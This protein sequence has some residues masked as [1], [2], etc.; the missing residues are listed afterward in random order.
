MIIVTTTDLRDLSGDDPDF[1]YPAG[2]RFE[3]D[4]TEDAFWIVTHDGQSFPVMFEE[5]VIEGE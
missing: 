3:V 5:A 4:S 1:F 2:T